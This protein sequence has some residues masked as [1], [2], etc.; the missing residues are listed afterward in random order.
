M[1]YLK[2]CSQNT[3]E[4]KAA[5]SKTTVPAYL[6]PLSIAK[7]VVYQAGKFQKKIQIAKICKLRNVTN[8]SQASWLSMCGKWSRIFTST[9]TRQLCF[10]CILSFYDLLVIQL[11]KRSCLR[12]CWP[13]LGTNSNCRSKP[14][15]DYSL[16]FSSWPHTAAVTALISLRLLLWVESVFGHF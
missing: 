2:N 4:Y 1:E 9:I 3:W 12:P 8:K 16:K 15:F 7:N 5:P 11:L 13:L 14:I 6:L 10:F